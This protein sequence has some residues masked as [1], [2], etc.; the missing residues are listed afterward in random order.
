MAT[1]KKSSKKQTE[2]YRPPLSQEAEDAEMIALA[3]DQARQQLRDGTAPGPVVLYLMKKGS[4]KE[5]LELEKLREENK[6]LIAK[7][8]ALEGA[9]RTEEMLEGYINSLRL[10]QGHQGDDDEP[11][12]F[13]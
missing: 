1:T 2:K 5:R 11:D 9:K 10:Y 13:Y 6:L 3:Y 8:K 4:E 12:D 7:T